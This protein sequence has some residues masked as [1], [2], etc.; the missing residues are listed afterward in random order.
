MPNRRSPSPPPA[1]DGEFDN[2]HL[3]EG[4]YPGDDDDA[5]NIY[6]ELDHA[7]ANSLGTYLDG[8]N[9]GVEP[10]EEYQEGGFHPV[11][12][13]DLL[14]ADNRYRVIHKLGHG[15]FGTVWLC[16]DTKDSRYVAVKVMI[17]DVTPDKVADLALISLD[18]SIPGAEYIGI[19][20][21]NFEVTGPNGTH[22]C[23]VLPV[24]GPCVS[25]S[26]WLKLDR[27]PAAVLRKLA[28]QSA[29]ALNF[30]HKNN[31]CHGD[32]RPSNILVKLTNLDRLSEDELFAL[33]GAPIQSQVKSELGDDLPAGSPNYLVPRADMSD[34]G[35][36]YLTEDICVIDFGESYPVD[37]PPEDLGI[38]ENYLP[39]D[40]LLQNEEE[41]LRDVNG[42]AC[43]V[44]A[45]GCTLFEIRQQIPLF[46][47]IYDRDELVAECVRFFG[48][49]PDG[50]WSEWA[51]RE[52]W[53]DDKGS[54]LGDPDNTEEWSLEVALSKPTEV[55]DPVK[56]VLSTDAKEQKLLA[57]LLYK[58]FQY[59]PG[60]RPS[61]D[62]VLGHEWFK[63]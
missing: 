50:W 58:V 34:L 41:P 45:L 19:P 43:D 63:L 54:Y 18:K 2:H 16:R 47:M 6:Q 11:H 59:E 30:L 3:M 23:I 8:I 38:P 49:L 17:A 5:S 57:D 60:K 22:Q 14:G 31:L 51:A 61:V 52:D 39:P 62:E 29:Q 9:D 25:P 28:R 48:K 44:W 55:I 24:L 21:G 40:I 4:E 37:S 26:L 35:S 33:I 20:L 13:G 56:K 53:F 36:K 27:D 1:E 42:P 46:Y 32:F 10:L 7:P 15:G 12:L